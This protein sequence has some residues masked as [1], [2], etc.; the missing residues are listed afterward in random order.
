MKM[1]GATNGFIRMPFVVE[2]LV[3][4]LTGTIIAFLAQWGIYELVCG[5]VMTSIAGTFISVLPFMSVA[6]PMGLVFLA[7]GLVVGVFGG[8]IAIKNYLKV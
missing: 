3:L 7:V 2:G 1:V 6:L 8:S 5:K 4:G